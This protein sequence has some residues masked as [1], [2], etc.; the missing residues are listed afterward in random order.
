[1]SSETGGV[2]IGTVIQ[3]VFIILKLTDNVG[4]TWFW[5]LSP[6][7]IGAGLVLGTWAFVFFVVVPIQVYREHKARKNRIDEMGGWKK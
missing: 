7:W 2:S 3:V 6:M 1:M 5:V 4:W